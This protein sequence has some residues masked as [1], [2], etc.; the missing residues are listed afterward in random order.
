MSAARARPGKR[1]ARTWRR[2][3]PPVLGGLLVLGVAGAL[4]WW[5]GPEE[6]PTAAERVA[7]CQRHH[8]LRQLP[9]TEA[10]EQV[11]RRCAWPA[12]GDYADGYHEIT[13]TVTEPEIDGDRVAY[14]IVSPCAQLAY[15]LAGA[16][17]PTWV[18]SG[19][20]VDGATGGPVNL[21]SE[22]LEVVPELSPGTLVVLTTGG[23]R[24]V[25]VACR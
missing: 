20:V 11:L 12:P 19:Q 14:T 17:G 6:E 4:W 10:P 21:T 13:V 7:S 18:E 9:L 1:R 22:L 8:G 5:L 23:R 25:D 2:L 16:A 24:L 15:E 3:V